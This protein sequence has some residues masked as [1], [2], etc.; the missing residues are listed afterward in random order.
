MKLSQRKIIYIKAKQFADDYLL[1]I[2]RAM[3]GRPDEQDLIL[4]SQRSV[5][6]QAMVKSWKLLESC[7][8]HIISFTTTQLI[9]LFE[10]RYPLSR[11]TLDQMLNTVRLQVEEQSEMSLELI[12]F[13]R[14]HIQ[15][16]QHN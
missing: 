13:T 10:R 16:G 8:V 4:K 3:F 2:L 9:L 12:R 11:F 6:G 1:T 14:Q 5:H 15:E 7:G